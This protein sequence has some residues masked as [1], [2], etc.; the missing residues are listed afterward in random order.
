MAYNPTIQ[1]AR[2]RV[3]KEDLIGRRIVRVD[4]R[5]FRTHREGVGLEDPGYWTTDPQILLDNGRWL[6]FLVEETDGDGYGVK[7]ILTPAVAVKPARFARL[8]N[9]LPCPFRVGNGTSSGTC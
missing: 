3:K 8:P 4:F 1:E 9:P 7:L 2:P 6:R 5:Q